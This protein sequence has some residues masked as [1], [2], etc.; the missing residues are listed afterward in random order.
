LALGAS[1]QL[2]TVAFAEVARPAA[3]TFGC[4][5]LVALAK[6][7]RKTL[8]LRSVGFAAVSTDSSRHS[9][10]RLSGVGEKG[11]GECRR[12]VNGRALG[13]RARR[14]RGPARVCLRL[15]RPH[16]APRPRGESRP[17]RARG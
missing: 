14:N 10:A 1:A 12:S 2:A 13:A 3:S 8:P 17:S 6:E 4:E 15:S 7:L 9:V 5:R 16:P 11:C